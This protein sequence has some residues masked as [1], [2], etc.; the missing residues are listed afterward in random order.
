MRLVIATSALRASLAIYHL[1]LNAHPHGLLIII[2][3][4]PY[5][6]RYRHEFPFVLLY[7]VACYLSGP[8]VAK[9]QLEEAWLN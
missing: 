6:K 8:K 4:L 3:K 9:F 2:W 5:S 7:S 1:I